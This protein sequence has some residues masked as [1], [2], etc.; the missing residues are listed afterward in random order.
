LWF[1]E[2]NTETERR[3]DSD[4]RSHHFKVVKSSFALDDH[5]NTF[6]SHSRRI[7]F[8]PDLTPTACDEGCDGRITNRTY[9][10]HLYA[11]ARRGFVLVYVAQY[12]PVIWLKV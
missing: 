1:S 5:S 12:T 3:R 10:L 9:L 4:V 11:A 6:D 8:T 2:A 7:K